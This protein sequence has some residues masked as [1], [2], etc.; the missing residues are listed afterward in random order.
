MCLCFIIIIII[1]ILEYCKEKFQILLVLIQQ[2]Y[3]VQ[4]ML[5]QCNGMTNTYFFDNAHN[6]W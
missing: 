5:I 3:S 1:F 2:F 6:P 4:N